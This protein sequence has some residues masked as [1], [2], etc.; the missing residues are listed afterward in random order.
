[1]EGWPRMWWGRADEEG[2]GL[3]RVVSE[4]TKGSSWE[5]S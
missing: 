4:M 1:M 2:A 3:W 5:D